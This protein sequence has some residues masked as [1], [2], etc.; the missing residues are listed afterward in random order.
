MTPYGDNAWVNI[1]SGNGLIPDG[2]KFYGKYA[3]VIYNLMF[4]PYSIQRW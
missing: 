1:G 2:T 4:V 3:K